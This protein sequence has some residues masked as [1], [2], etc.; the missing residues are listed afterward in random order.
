MQ[1]M[2]T[3]MLVLKV[4]SHSPRATPTYEGANRVFI[5]SDIVI[6]LVSAPVSACKVLGSRNVN[7]SWQ[8][9]LEIPWGNPH[10]LI[11][12]SNQL[13]GYTLGPQCSPRYPPSP[14]DMGYCCLHLDL[15]RGRGTKGLEVPEPHGGCGKNGRRFAFSLL[16]YTMLEGPYSG[17]TQK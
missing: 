6:T 4:N 9:F 3:C 11:T 1:E 15:Q 12:K 14:A 13:P 8:V 7:I 17:E 10:E 16:S 2:R 5:S